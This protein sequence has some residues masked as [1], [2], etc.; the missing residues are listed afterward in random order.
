M[1]PEYLTPYIN[2]TAK[3][4]GGFDSLLWASPLTQRARF[5]AITQ[6]Y[7]FHDK[8]VLD[9][10]CGLADFY[11]HLLSVGQIPRQYIGLEAVPQLAEI[12]RSS[13]GQLIVTADFIAEPA[14]LFV[15][16]D[17]IVFSGSFN[18]C[19]DEVMLSVLGRALDAA[20]DAVLFNFLSNR[21]RAGERYLFWR[22]VADVRRHFVKRVTEVRED[23]LPGD[24]TMIV[25]KHR[26]ATADAR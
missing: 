14:R 8:I 24:A 9:A 20:S 4:E 16:A 13:T 1:Q 25:R 26:D 2:A 5:G 12:A 10:G 11:D 23:Y 6:M 17:V 19:A 21:S 7:D 22:S 18:T 15:G 3:S